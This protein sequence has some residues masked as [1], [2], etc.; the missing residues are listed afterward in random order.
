MRINSSKGGYHMHEFTY[1]M[2][3]ARRAQRTIDRDALSWMGFG[4]CELFDLVAASENADFVDPANV[5]T[6]RTGLESLFALY[7]GF[8]SQDGGRD[9]AS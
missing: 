4:L 7:K 6:A 5:E 2:N 8:C 3:D 9:Q 1:L